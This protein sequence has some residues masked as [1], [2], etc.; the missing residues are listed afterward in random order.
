MRQYL[1]DAQFD[2]S[3]GFVADAPAYGGW[4]LQRAVEPGKSGHMDLAHTRRAL[5][6]LNRWGTLPEV[7]AA[8]GRADDEA[9]FGN[10]RWT[11]NRR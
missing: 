3:D 5:E 11:P 1:V 4:G 6:A 10:R 7:A 8:R 2:E 9:G